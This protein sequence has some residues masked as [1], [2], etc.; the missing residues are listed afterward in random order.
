MGGDLTEREQRVW[1][2]IQPSVVYLLQGTTVSGTATLIDREGLFLADRAAFAGAEVEGR[3][4]DGNQVH[5]KLIATDDPTQFVLLKAETWNPAFANPVTVGDSEGSLLA[6]TSNGPIRAERNSKSG[7]YF[8]VL[9]NSSRRSMPL[10]E[11]RLENTQA[12]L[13]GALLFSLDGQLVGALNA[14][15]EVPGGQ[16]NLQNRGGGGF[17]G[18]AG[19]S[20]SD[21]TTATTAKMQLIPQYGPGMMAT[22]YSV[23]S[24]VLKRV[25]DGFVSPSHEVHHPT[26]GIICGNAIPL[27]ALIDSV[28]DG[29]TASKAGLR[30]NDIIMAINGQAVQNQFDF[31]KV[32]STQEVGAN[33]KVTVKRDGLVQ[34]IDVTVGSR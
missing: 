5:F 24:K 19:R 23:S 21:A 25:V 10:T 28:K 22:G 34:T 4:S 26:I 1:K 18:G 31:I 32:M 6:V 27:G 29:S 2:K 16:S 13:G 20:Q 17:G 11:I 15:L 3:A 8:G 12:N 14:T 30:K 9:N 33:L 7:A